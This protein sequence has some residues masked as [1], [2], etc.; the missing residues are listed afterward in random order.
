[1]APAASQKARR[2]RRASQALVSEPESN[3]KYGVTV[4]SF[5]GEFREAPQVSGIPG[6]FG[7]EWRYVFAM[8]NL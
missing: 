3:T 6:K 5:R 7:G 1:V 4:G 8:K 2:L